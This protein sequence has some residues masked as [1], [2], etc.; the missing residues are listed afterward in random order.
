MRGTAMGG[1]A[2]YGNG[3]V[4]AACHAHAR[5]YIQIGRFQASPDMLSIDGIHTVQHTL[6]H[7][8]LRAEAGF[9]CRLEQQLYI[10]FQ[11]VLD[12]AQD[13]GGTQQHCH[14]VIMTA[15][16]H[17]AGILT[18]EGQAGLFL[19]R[20]CVNIRTQ[21]HCLGTG[22]CLSAVNHRST[23][24]TA[25]KPMYFQ[26]HLLQLFLDVIGGAELFPGQFRMSME[27]AALFD[28]IAFIFFCQCSNIHRVFLLYRNPF[29]LSFYHTCPCPAIVFHTKNRAFL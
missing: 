27:P 12:F 9:L 16:M 26:T 28:D 29:V 25:F 1:T 7:I 11:L 17:H 2:L 23:A 21:G 3:E 22:N 19:H 10:A 24:G 5:L 13:L 20:Q 8:I 6:L 18:G 15:G 14:V 4:I